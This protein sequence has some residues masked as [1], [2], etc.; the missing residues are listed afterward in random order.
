MLSKQVMILFKAYYIMK[1]KH[2]QYFSLLR[3][4]LAIK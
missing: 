1:S 3:V 2:L 4:E